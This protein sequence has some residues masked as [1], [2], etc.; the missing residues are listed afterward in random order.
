MKA[1]PRGTDGS[2]LN[3]LPW[4]LAAL[5][6]S[7]APHVPFLPVWVTAAFLGCAGWRY[8]VEMRRR[9]LPST[10]LRAGLALGCFLGV[11]AT[12]S[13]I[14]GVGPGSALLAVMAAL[15]LLETRKRRDQFVL[16]FLSI[17]LVMSALLREQYVWSVP[18]M[19]AAMLVIMTAWL[20]MSAGESQT[21]RQSFA[22]GG[23]LLAYAAPLAIVM[24]IFF[25]RI[26]TPFWA[27]PIDTSRATSGLSETMS[28]GDISSLSMSDAVAFRVRFDG[29]IPEPRDRYWRGLVLTRFNGRTWTGREPSISRMARDQ[30]E[31]RG[32]PIEYEVTLEPTQ[33]QWV[34]ALDMPMEWSLPQTFMGPQQ[35]LA[36]SIPI[37][38]RIQYDVV[39]YP[40]FRVGTELSTLYRNW[41]SEL[42]ESGNMRTRELARRMR[43]EAGSDRAFVEA[44]LRMLHEQEFYY[45]LEPPP[46]GSN[47]VDRFLFDTR[48]GFCEHYAS[49]FSVMMRS[50]GIPA[51]VVL[52]YQGGEVN[53]L[54]GHL[55]VR[56]SDAHAW[57][58]IWIDNLGWWRVDP[59]AAVAPERVD[60]G[61]GEAALDGIGEAW[62]F[63]APSR[64]VYQ[65]S[66]AWDAVNAKW[67]EWVLGYGPD[68]QNAFMQWLGMHE[69][70]WRK[71]MLTL[72]ILVIGLIMVISVLLMLR[73]RPPQKDEV[74][75]LYARYVKKTGMEPR[76]G[77]TARVFALRVRDAGV[78]Q[79]DT[80][81]TIT[82]AYMD[83]RYGD[84][85]EAADR[86]HEEVSAIS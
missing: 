48:R 51:R 34:F 43:D 6:V 81:E 8:Y 21:A 19:I 12:Y 37:D 22:T 66:M 13:S 11:L 56:Q 53:P 10:W 61:A 58:E 52:G 44:V 41:Y 83:A 2:L 65:V 76:T 60:I 17:F 28:P 67:N 49:A 30:I 38:Q 74:A 9:P 35:Q 39:S 80:V 16:L 36:R 63:S 57:T 55:I 20:R 78:M 69:P 73:Y 45:T 29:V 85:E 84:D 32:E 50:V 59:T 82:A 27:V 24:W 23:R 15:K 54:G 5:V 7:I 31:P 68:T 33:Q 14:S 1:R 4:T 77:E 75:L 64:W 46:L 26:S 47:P 3:S 40:D 79:D 18:Y 25:P 71:M 86:L 70:T 72:V 62:G 42:P